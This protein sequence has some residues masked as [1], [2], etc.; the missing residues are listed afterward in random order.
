[1]GDIELFNG[2]PAAASVDAVGEAL[3]LLLPMEAARREIESNIPLL[4]VLALGL[5][6]KL[7]SFNATSAVNLNYL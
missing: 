4:K 1:M 3:C 2:N 6:K 5:A 7:V